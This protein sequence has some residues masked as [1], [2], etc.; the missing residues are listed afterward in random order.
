MDGHLVNIS[1]QDGHLVNI[2]TR[3]GHLV[4][5]ST[6]D[7]HLVNISREGLG[8]GMKQDFHTCV[9]ACSRA[10]MQVQDCQDGKAAAPDGTEPQVPVALLS[11]RLTSTVKNKNL[12]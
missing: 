12:G 8:C 7:G 4:N 2:S 6:R 3:D 11:F 1:T 10:S 9:R 5:I